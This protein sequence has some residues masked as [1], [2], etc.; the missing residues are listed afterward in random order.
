MVISI[1]WD[2]K[3]EAIVVTGLAKKLLSL[4]GQDLAQIGSRWIDYALDPRTQDALSNEVLR[5][6]TGHLAGSAKWQLERR[7][8]GVALV[9]RSAVYGP[10]HE[11][12]GTIT[13]KRAQWLTVPLPAAMT[14]AGV[15]K[16]RARDFP[17]TFVAR[18]R[19]GN[20]IIFQRG[21]GGGVTPLFVLKKKVTIPARRWASISVEES[22]DGLDRIVQQ[23]IDEKGA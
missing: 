14:P 11:F 19:A 22:L 1:R 5:R 17:S 2:E 13:P 3:K 18:S 15:V 16:G 8:R 12:G 21:V 10:I 9:L 7:G 20:L 23:V 4:S 6:R